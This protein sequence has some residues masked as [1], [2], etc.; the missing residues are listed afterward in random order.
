MSKTSEVLEL[1]NNL[2]KDVYIGRLFHAWPLHGV[3]IAHLE[4]GE[5]RAIIWPV[6]KATN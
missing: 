1:N 3:V 4:P 2:L 5:M 6:T